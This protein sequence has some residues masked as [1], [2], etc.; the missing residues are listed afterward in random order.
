MQ[1][2]R[3]NPSR[4]PRKHKRHATTSVKSL[5]AARLTLHQYDPITGNEDV[6]YTLFYESYRGYTIYSTEQGRCCIHGRDGCLRIRGYY[7]CFPDVEQAKNLIKHFQAD[8]RTPQE[9]M[10]RYVPE[11]TYRCLNRKTVHLAHRQLAK[12]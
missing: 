9:S 10:N 12:V 11:E 6:L 7:A 4:K 1:H 2:K 5:E 3:G 8:G